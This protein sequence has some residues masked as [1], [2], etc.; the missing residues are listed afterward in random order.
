MAQDLYTRL[1]ANHEKERQH[2][3]FRIEHQQAACSMGAASEI[4]VLRVR[5]KVGLAPPAPAAAPAAAPPAAPPPAAPPAAAAPAAA[6]ASATPPTAAA[7][8]PPVTL[9]TGGLGA[10]HAVWKLTDQSDAD[11]H[12]HHLSDPV[13][14]AAWRRKVLGQRC[15]RLIGDGRHGC[16]VAV[17]PEAQVESVHRERGYTTDRSQVCSAIQLEFTHDPSFDSVSTTTVAVGG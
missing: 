8:A 17:L 16:R 6:A 14:D 12:H 3:L 15:R 4:V 2:Q 10:R 13:G 1:K 5:G 7:T 11:H 9:A